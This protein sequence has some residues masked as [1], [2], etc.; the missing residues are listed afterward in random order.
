M[1][2][3]IL[4][5]HLLYGIAY[6]GKGQQLPN[7]SSF[8]ENGFIWNPA[9]TAQWY[10]WEASVTQRQEWT[11]FQYAPQ[12]TTAAFQVPLSDAFFQTQASFGGFVQRDR[13]GPYNIM[14]IAGTYSYKITPQFFGNNKDMLALGVLAEAKYFGVDEGRI[15]QFQEV[16]VETLSSS[17]QPNLSIG[18]FYRSNGYL[19]NKKDHFFFGA[20]AH[21]LLPF[22]FG[23]VSIGGFTND[24]YA[25]AHGGF[26]AFTSRNF[27]L[28]P[29]M[30][31]VYGY[32]KATDVMLSLR[33]E[34]FE[35]MWFGA[36]GSTTGEV[37]GQVGVV[38]NRRSFIGGLIGNG[39]L[40]MGVKADYRVGSLNNFSGL[41][42]E[43]YVA[44]QYEIE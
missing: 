30:M 39:S 2:R 12:Y 22:T 41:G 34:A 38:M 35:K 6:I 8:Y 28:E 15:I 31:V 43:V 13:I 29:N 10:S 24:F 26:R 32:Q 16:G 23:D 44:Y 9:L 37:F 42:Y 4:I 36:G 25:A 18:F 19:F 21:R 14:G 17:Y 5:L 3:L 11:G 1:K 7:W 27:Y 20:A 40:R 33:A